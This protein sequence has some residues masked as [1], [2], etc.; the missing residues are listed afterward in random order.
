MTVRVDLMNVCDNLCQLTGSKCH[1]SLLFKQSYLVG[2]NVDERIIR[3]CRSVLVE[4]EDH[5]GEMSIIRCRTTELVIGLSW[6][7]R[8]ACQILQLPTPT[9]VTNHEVKF[10]VRTEEDLPSVVIAPQWLS[11]ISLERPQHDDVL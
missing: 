8:S 5:A 9:L 3:W 11:R 6:A 4:P 10:T 7:K 1:A 2:C